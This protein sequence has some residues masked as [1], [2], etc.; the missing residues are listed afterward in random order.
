M[1]WADIRGDHMRV[2]VQKTNRQIDVAILEALQANGRLSN[3]ELAQRVFEQIGGGSHA[4]GVDVVPQLCLSVARPRDGDVFV[5]QS[6]IRRFVEGKE[7]PQGPDLLALVPL[8]RL[9]Q[10]GPPSFTSRMH[11]CPKVRVRTLGNVLTSLGVNMVQG[12][13]M[14]P[15][16]GRGRFNLTGTFR[17]VGGEPIVDVALGGPQDEYVPPLQTDFG[18][19]RGHRPDPVGVVAGQPAVP[20]DHGVHR[21]DG[22][23]QGVD[24][25]AKPEHRLLVRDGD[26]AAAPVGVPAAPIGNP[27]SVPTNSAPSA[28]SSKPGRVDLPSAGSAATVAPYEVLVE[29]KEDLYVTYSAGKGLEAAVTYLSDGEA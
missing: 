13:E 6:L 4:F 10:E 16:P 25:V 1:S 14:T 2:R 27:R 8:D 12:T 11:S 22:P 21:P 23:R 17:R 28:L 20:V 7:A 5:P 19:E 18:R 29:E 9:Q 24:A 15:A 3:L 26:V